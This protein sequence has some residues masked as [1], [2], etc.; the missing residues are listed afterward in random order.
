[1]AAKFPALAENL[2]IW[3]RA[4]YGRLLEVVSR[5]CNRRKLQ[6]QPLQARRSQ[7]VQSGSKTAAA[8]LQ[9]S[10][11]QEQETVGAGGIHPGTGG[12]ALGSRAEAWWLGCFVLSPAPTRHIFFPAF[13]YTKKIITLGH[14]R[15]PPIIS[16]QPSLLFQR[17]LR[18]VSVGTG[19]LALRKA[20]LC[21][22]LP[23]LKIRDWTTGEEEAGT[24]QGRTHSYGMLVY[25]GLVVG[26]CALLKVPQECFKK[27][28]A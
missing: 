1:M 17:L 23:V 5:L 14:P 13:F 18:S 11:C 4:L 9:P 25:L 28:L 2:C 22:G 12:S 24:S 7:P 21:P 26:T 27:K 16:C 20:S 10:G 6:P 3:R 19:H 15:V 8:D